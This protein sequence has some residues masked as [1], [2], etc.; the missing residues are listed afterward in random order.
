[1]ASFTRQGAAFSAQFDR[2]GSRQG[3]LPGLRTGWLFGRSMVG[4]AAAS[5]EKMIAYRMT[6]CLQHIYAHDPTLSLYWL[7]YC[8]RRA[9]AGPVRLLPWQDLSDIQWRQFREGLPMATAGMAAYAAASQL[10]RSGAG[11]YSYWPPQKTWRLLSVG[12][13][14]VPCANVRCCCA[15]FA[16][17]AR[18]AA[19][20]Q[21][22]VFFSIFR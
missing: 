21:Y 15:G 11:C 2:L 5:P 4:A 9:L 3:E 17:K 8:T 16:I 18:L 12:L 6:S 22:R 1:M 19:P 14:S 20:F 7:T 10:V 13:L